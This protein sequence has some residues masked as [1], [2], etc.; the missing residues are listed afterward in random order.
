MATARKL[1]AGAAEQ[2]QRTRLGL[3]ARADHEDLLDHV[4]LAWLGIGEDDAHAAGGR[5]A[6]HPD[7]LAGREGG[8]RARA[9]VA[10][11][12]VVDGLAENLVRHGVGPFLT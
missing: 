4:G 6:R 11:L 5:V 8:G 1:G 9:A 12:R 10:R 7:E 2:R 3:R